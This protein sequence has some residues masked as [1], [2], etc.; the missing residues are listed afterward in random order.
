VLSNHYSSPHGGV[1][2][3][4]HAGHREVSLNRLPRNLCHLKTRDFFFEIDHRFDSWECHDV[5]RDQHS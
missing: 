5:R 1:G 4:Q 3:I 2:T